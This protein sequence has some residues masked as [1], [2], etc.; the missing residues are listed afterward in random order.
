[1]GKLVT[2]A[3]VL[4]L[5]VRQI[6]DFDEKVLNYQ[7]NHNQQVGYIQQNSDDCFKMLLAELKPQEVE[8]LKELYEKMFAQQTALYEKIILQQREEIVFLRSLLQK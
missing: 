4:E 7:C 5:D 3:K 2:I 1:M 6:L 8:N